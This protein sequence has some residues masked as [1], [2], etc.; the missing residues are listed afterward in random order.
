M[1]QTKKKFPSAVKA[2]Y[3]AGKDHSAGT[4]AD[5]DSGE[6]HRP[7]SSRAYRGWDREL[8]AMALASAEYFKTYAKLHDDSSQQTKD[9]AIKH[10]AKNTIKAQKAAYE[11][12]RDNSKVFDFEPTKIYDNIV[13]HLEDV[14]EE[15]EKE[16]DD[17]E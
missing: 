8:R 15:F 11:V 6:Y 14:E 1:S 13:E 7:A 12:L 5:V 2:I 17:E 4:S 3:I 9:G 10:F 16:V